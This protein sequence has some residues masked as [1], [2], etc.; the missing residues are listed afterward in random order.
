M[1]L[2][3]MDLV[4]PNADFAHHGDLSSLSHVS[5]ECFKI[6]ATWCEFSII[7]QNLIALLIAKALG[8][9]KAGWPSS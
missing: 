4:E 2:M 7:Q 6:H 5:D 9:G 3:T 8:L 1:I